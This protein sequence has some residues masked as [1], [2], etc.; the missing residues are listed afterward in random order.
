MDMTSAHYLATMRYKIL[1]MYLKGASVEVPHMGS[2]SNQSIEP[3]VGVDMQS[4]ASPAWPG[5]LECVLRISLHARYEGR[6]VFML[7]VTEAAVF[8]LDL[9]NAQDAHRFVRKIAPSVLFPLARKDLANLAVAAGFQPVLLDHVDFD[10]LLTQVIESHRSAVPPKPRPEM[11][12]AKTVAP[13]V[14]SPP[15]EKSQQVIAPATEE[16]LG[17]EAD[18]PDTL[19]MGAY[20]EPNQRSPSSARSLGWGLIGIASITATIAAMAWYVQSHQQLAAP[21]SDATAP[22]QLQLAPATSVTATPN[23]DAL[24]QQIQ[25]TIDN[26]RTRLAEQPPDWFTLDLG[27]VPK[28]ATWAYFNTLP[29]DRAVFILPSRIAELHLLYGVFPTQAAA[30]RAGQ[31]L[32]QSGS[33]ADQPAAVITQISAL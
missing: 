22:R 24:A 2:L 6:N 25:A 18:W 3:E 7:E 23:T 1:R 10:S 4:E 28:D 17:Q 9:S 21:Q 27:T 26:S 33:R 11:I 8:E 20:V 13:V 12:A 5:A 32:Q 15:Q 14:P 30:E 29:K 31:E 19:P 16:A